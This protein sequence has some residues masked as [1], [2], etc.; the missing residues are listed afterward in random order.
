VPGAQRAEQLLYVRD[1]ARSRSEP[2]E[3]ITASGDGD[4]QRQREQRG[5]PGSIGGAAVG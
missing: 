1:R 4:E 2:G 5:A 3:G